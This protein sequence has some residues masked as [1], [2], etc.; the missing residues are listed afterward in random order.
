M[1]AE[2]QTLKEREVA[3][4]P[5]L[6]R[7]RL[8]ERVETL[9]TD[10]RFVDF[11]IRPALEF[12]IVGSDTGAQK[13][14]DF[15]WVIKDFQPDYMLVSLDFADPTAVSATEI[16]DLEMTI[17]HGDLF[18]LESTGEAIPNGYV[19]SAELLP[20][21]D[22]SAQADWTGRGE[23][24]ANTVLVILLVALFATVLCQG[25]LIAVFGFFETIQLISHLPLVNFYMPYTLL[26]F[27]KPINDFVRFSFVFESGV[28]QKLID[29]F[30]IHE[31]GKFLN[32]NFKDLGYE[33]GL[34]LPNTISVVVALGCVLTLMVL[35]LC[36][37][38]ILDR[39]QK[40]QEKLRGNII[41]VLMNALVRFSI[42]LFLELLLCSWLHFKSLNDYDFGGAAWAATSTWFALGALLASAVIFLIIASQIFPKKITSPFARTLATG[43]DVANLQRSAAYP[44]AVVTRR[45]FYAL[46]LVHLD[47]TPPL[48]LILL[49]ASSSLM[50]YVLLRTRPFEVRDNLALQL[51]NEVSVFLITGLM[52]AFTEVNWHEGDAEL[53]TIVTGLIM[54]TMVIMLMVNV[55]FITHSCIFGALHAYRVRQ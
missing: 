17:W 12:N 55:L 24:Y 38:L 8:E 25:S 27:L 36:V 54:A 9:L 20:Q 14:I 51:F 31:D 11:K 22:E 7:R 34:F 16:D 40:R 21:I 43:L 52:F 42:L 15:D 46:I 5:R 41:P 26:T 13:N 53:G 35:V 30:V 49:M 23:R 33:S 10:T 44:L 2:W 6:S 45:V 3:F 28:G 50:M 18:K 19:I 47:S 1:P 32:E 48:Q 29:F 4:D 37:D 39:L